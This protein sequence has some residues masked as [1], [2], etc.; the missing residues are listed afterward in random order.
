MLEKNI[1]PI[2]AAALESYLK[3]NASQKIISRG[4]AYFNQGRVKYKSYDK[5][6]KCFSLQVIGNEKYIVELKFQPDSYFNINFSNCN[7]PYNFGGLCKHEVAAVL[8]LKSNFEFLK[9]AP[10][11]SIDKS[12]SN[13]FFSLKNFADLTLD[14]FNSKYSNLGH[15]YER[16]EEFID[17]EISERSQGHFEV[18]LIFDLGFYNHQKIEKE[19]L[20]I[21][22]KGKNLE[23]SCSCDQVH[24]KSL[25]IHAVEFINE[26][27]HENA[28]DNFQKISEKQLEEHT[29]KV[30]KEFGFSE[31]QHWSEFFEVKF[32]KHKRAIVLNEKYE[33]FLSP[34]M[35][36]NGSKLV[37]ND[38]KEE[39]PWRDEAFKEDKRDLG[40]Y[41]HFNSNLSEVSMVAIS[42]KANKKGERMSISFKQYES[43]SRL[44]ES[45]LFKKDD[46]YLINLAE[47]IHFKQDFDE[48]AIGLFKK[49]EEQ[50]ANHP[51]L[52]Y[53][54][55]ENPDYFVKRNLE[56]V[57][58]EAFPPKITY[59]L[60]RGKGNVVE[61]NSFVDHDGKRLPISKA[62]II[63]LHPFFIKIEET[64]YFLN[65]K[66]DANHF[67]V[68]TFL[69]GKKINQERFEA[70]FNSYLSQV[71]KKHELDQRHQEALKV[72]TIEL[73]S[74]EKEVY[75]SEVGGF[76][77]LRP[78][79]KYKNNQ[80]LNVLVEKSDWTYSGD[81]LI[82]RKQDQKEVE[83]FKQLLLELHLD[84]AKQFRS[85]YLHIHF[86]KLL[87]DNLFFKFF[88]RLKANKVRVFG[89]NKL[90][91]FKI[92]PYPAKVKYSV[93]SG[94]DWFE[95]ETKLVFGDVEISI[96]ELKKRFIPGNE[97][98]E[99][100]NGNMGMIPKEWLEKLEK[101]LR[102]GEINQGKLRLSSKKFNII[103]ELFEQ[104]DD[105]TRRFIDV[106]KQKLLQFKGI[107]KQKLPAGIKA[108][109]RAYQK[110][111]YHWLCFLDDF[112][113]G[114]ILA[115]DMGLGKTLQVITF[116]KSVIKKDK[117]TNLIVVPTSLLFNWENEFKKF[118]PGI[119]VHFHYGPK[120][121][122]DMEK[123]N[124]YHI[125]VTTYGHL[126]S[127]IKQLKDYPFNYVVLDE[128]QA[129]KNPASKRYKSA[130]LLNSKNRIA[131]TGTPIENNTFDL[132][133]QMSFLNPGLLGSVKQFKETF[134]NAIDLKRDQQKAKELQSIIKPFVLRRTKEQVATELPDKTEETLYCE[135]D[136]G[137]RKVYDS[138]R[139]KYRKI[140]MNKIET[141]G[142]NKSRFAV[143][144]GLTKLRQICDSPQI[145]SGEEKYEGKSVKID[146]L[147]EH[148][149]EKTAKH[150]ILIFS[151]FVSM[152]K[153]IESKIQA[154]KIEYAYLDGK[155]SRKQRE[156][157]VNHFQTKESCRVFLISLKAG[158]TGLNLMAADYVYIVDPWWNPAVE[159]Q[160]IDRCYRI[161]Q[162]KN[163][164]AYKMIC[165]NTVEEKI[166]ALQ[167]KKKAIAG[168]I[169]STDEGV[170]K[171]MDQDDLIG[172]FS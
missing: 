168:D 56:K 37:Q 156:E 11:L 112:C 82:E 132:Y 138:F 57:N 149:K 22:R 78:F 155:S 151:Q 134:A 137:Q 47:K 139:N 146:L 99:L 140:L 6:Q 72:K 14:S 30:K 124:Q 97:Y 64:L 25:C 121:A 90:S 127:E 162:K 95:I 164:I 53:H 73:N 111:G 128:S 13:S 52:Y 157:N 106:K 55:G 93:K 110:E 92:N 135:M 3:V 152:L 49:A 104:V 36:E 7:C 96:E 34:L 88:E 12:Q 58:Y 94:L 147:I 100:K 9:T 26:M 20:S 109:L 133:A 61:T 126:I 51:F 40:F 21:I 91:K 70:F 166:V 103:D 169:I 33:D 123:F 116:L 150:K 60:K 32:N 102:H 86:D 24:S 129:I 10:W 105:E 71:L 85:D 87:K 153:T 67:E 172:L 39:L 19:T 17:F 120:R 62:G 142:L 165:K 27:L 170:L 68:A 31:E 113:W 29:Y 46:Y 119:K 54:N 44:T 130:R 158:G 107:E 154:E 59:Q 75:L 8:W 23:I 5:E 66:A 159:S 161:G 84:F 148:I 63:K 74:M 41:F 77:V 2:I 167:S 65:N 122:K 50:L 38:E 118:A 81:K 1:K 101:M 171:K 16:E 4:K 144:E 136:T 76:M 80:R 98:I 108:S 125:V 145:L 115:D 18:D 79:L 43:Y 15:Y 48:E 117:R 141:E 163:V 160:A 131:M 28:L 35:F 114:G 89:L 143:L 69:D 83:E 42:G 45:I